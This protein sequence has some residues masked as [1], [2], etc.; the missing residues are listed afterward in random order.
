MLAQDIYMVDIGSH[1]A[2]QQFEQL[3]VREED[4][5]ILQNDVRWNGLR[6]WG[7]YLGFLWQGNALM[8]DPTQA[9][10]EDLPLIFSDTVTLSATDFMSRVA[11]VFPVLD[12]GRY[13]IEVES[14]LD[15]SNWR[16]PEREGLLSTSLSRA[17]W[18]LDQGGELVLVKRADTKD[19]RVL[20]RA[21]GLDWINFTHVRY[22][23]MSK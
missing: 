16:K 22:T 23:G 10:R 21:G 2:I 7:R 12:G 14:V 8:I 1:V 11:E 4:R 15:S 9:L 3:Q 5:R 6:S 13:R 20:Q 17:L 18:R 19:G